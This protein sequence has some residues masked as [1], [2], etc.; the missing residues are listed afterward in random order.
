MNILVNVLALIFVFWLGWSIGERDGRTDA[1]R[2]Q[3]RA[4][5]QEK[6]AQARAKLERSGNGGSGGV[7][8]SEP[9]APGN[10]DE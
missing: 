4:R 1:L 9:I 5:A 6:L 8:V 2:M 10:R 7:F 3:R